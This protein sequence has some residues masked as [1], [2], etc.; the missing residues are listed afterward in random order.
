MDP[1]GTVG[2]IHK[3]DYYTMLH[4]KYESSGPCDFEEY[5]FFTFFPIVSL[6]ELL[7][8]MKA[9]VLIRPGP[10]PNTNLPLPQYCF[11]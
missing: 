6:W 3:E 1:R 2:R 8:S 4:T 11:R 5:D 7:V 10:K 9:R